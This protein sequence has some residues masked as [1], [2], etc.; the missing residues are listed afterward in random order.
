[1]VYVLSIEPTEYTPLQ[2]NALE[3][4]LSES[5]QLPERVI[6]AHQIRLNQAEIN[7]SQ[8][9]HPLDRISCPLTDIVWFIIRVFVY[10]K[11]GC[12]EKRSV[13]S[14]S[15]LPPEMKT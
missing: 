7:V 14:K 11:L 6:S 8:R 5:R 13:S 12:R 15:A 2:E 3:T 10:L 4:S 1:M 9:P